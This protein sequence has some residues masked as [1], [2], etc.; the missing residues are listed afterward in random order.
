MSKYNMLA[1]MIEG[2]SGCSIPLLLEDSE[3]PIPDGLREIISRLYDEYKALQQQIK[4]VEAR[5]TELLK[6]EPL[7]EKL[8]ET[9]G[10]GLV[11]TLGFKHQAFPLILR[12]TLQLFGPQC[13]FESR[14]RPTVRSND[15][16]PAPR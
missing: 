7:A 12:K 5:L 14:Y 4:Q 10:V 11:T 16:E 13:R 9:H 2:E 8:M 15:F 6:P 3:A 1:S